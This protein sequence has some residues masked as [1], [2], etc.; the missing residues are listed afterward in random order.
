MVQ[1]VFEN[2]EHPYE[3]DVKR[4][5]L[6]HPELFGD[7]GE[8]RVLSEKSIN[9]YHVIADLLIFS[10]NKG[11]IGI[12]IKTEHDSTQ[13]LN[14][15]L[16]AYE[17]LCTEV[18]VFTH[19]SLYSSVDKVL[20][21]NKHPSVG[22]YTYSAYN[23]EIYFGKMKQSSISKEFNVI[24]LLNIFWYTE[25]SKIAHTISVSKANPQGSEFN[26]R[27]GTSKKQLI[28]YI[29][30]RLGALGAYQIVIDMV[31]SET[32]DPRK[33]IKYYHFKKIPEPDI[34]VD[35]ALIKRKKN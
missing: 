12:E 32:N 10:K 26:V 1:K 34:K 20:T 16:R 22:I 5:I 21:A 17:S 4:A 9:E 7:L 14:K 3:L 19:D 11:V 31:I 18:W 13:R 24:H 23:D 15:Q 6:K 33:V 30:G 25:I 28:R 2:S 35:Y 8:T 29:K 27:R